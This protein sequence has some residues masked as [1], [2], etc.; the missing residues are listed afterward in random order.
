M[1]RTSQWLRAAVGKFWSSAAR[2]SR[3]IVPRARL[4]N[5]RAKRPRLRACD[6][7]VMSTD[8]LVARVGSFIR[9]FSVLRD[10]AATSKAGQRATAAEALRRALLRRPSA[11]AILAPPTGAPFAALRAFGGRG[12]WRL[13]PPTPRF[14]IG[15]Y[16]L[17]VDVYFQDTETDRWRTIFS[18]ATTLRQK[19]LFNGNM[20]EDTI[21]GDLACS[22]TPQWHTAGPWPLDD[23]EFRANDNVDDVDD[24]VDE[25]SRRLRV[26]AAIWRSA[27]RRLAPLLGEDAHPRTLGI[28]NGNMPRDWDFDEDDAFASGGAEHNQNEQLHDE[29]REIDFCADPPQDLNG[30]FSFMCTVSLEETVLADGRT[31][32]VP[33]SGEGRRRCVRCS[34]YEC[35]SGPDPTFACLLFRLE[36]LMERFA[37]LPS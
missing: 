31:A 23:L 4:M 35:G 29:F 11:A 3:S 2:V 7:V 19:F 28:A 17:L 32:L 9:D 13:P 36:N 25:V 34:F 27:D 10:L 22:N 33:R 8:D 12:P 37:P 18:T 5:P 21:R 24:L 6:C 30:T 14:E 20:P 16:T 15:A 1:P 26:R